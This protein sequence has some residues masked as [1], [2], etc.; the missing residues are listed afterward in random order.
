VTDIP[1][2]I[3]LA[4]SAIGEAGLAHAAIGGCAR[5]AYAEPR[6]TRD[7]DFVVQADPAGHARLVVALGRRG[8]VRATVA[9]TAEEAVP[10]FESFRDAAGQRID[11]LFAKTRF[12]ESALLRARPAMPYRDVTLPVVSAE[13]L[14][15]YK[16]IAGRTQ[17][18]ADLEVVVRTELVRVE[19]GGPDFD[20]SYVARWAAE[21]D[22]EDR[23]ADLR[24]R[25][26]LDAPP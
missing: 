19:H 16:L 8:F 17:D 24:R 3:A 18:W 6:A 2:L 10:D 12:E 1:T 20:W 4:S 9:S 5:N 26:G 7:V 14:V 21:W 25:V 11:L 15:V 23:L 22:I 13:D